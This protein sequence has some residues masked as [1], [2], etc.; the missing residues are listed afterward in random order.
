MFP[1]WGLSSTSQ[2]ALA[3]QR[4]P[5]WAP[6]IPGAL[7]HGAHGEEMLC[8][9]QLSEGHGVLMSSAPWGDPTDS[10]GGGPGPV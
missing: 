5:T 6:G 8:R 2:G 10:T 3:T 7:R 9:V 4:A 1:F